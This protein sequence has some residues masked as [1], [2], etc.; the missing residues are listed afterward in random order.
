MLA[1]CSI[2]GVCGTYTGCA[3]AV[4]AT[5]ETTIRRTGLPVELA[6]A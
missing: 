2:S 6:Q 3:I 1:R 4:G 5:A